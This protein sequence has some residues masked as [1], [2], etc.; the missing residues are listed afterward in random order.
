MAL[1]V[2]KE[3]ALYA[4]FMT[5]IKARSFVVEVTL[6]NLVENA[7]RNS[8][9]AHAEAEKAVLQVRFMCELVALASLAAHSTHGLS[10]DLLKSWHA[11][12]TF[13]L[14][15]TINPLC[16]PAP[17]QMTPEP[18][19]TTHL[20]VREAGALNAKG[21]ESIYNSCGQLLHRGVIKHVL[22]RT[23][24]V[25]DLDKIFGWTN[26][27]IGL[28]NNHIIMIQKHKGCF[29]ARLGTDPND[30][31]QVAWAE[32]DSEFVLGRR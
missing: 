25:Y 3:I 4:N 15:K 10:K 6:N 32:A 31:V 8:P 21:L 14:L 17:V 29:I 23:P 19:G 16:F 26:Q 28:L 7:D 5:E 22:Q 9:L 27:I 1:K 11:D 30:P 13:R 20:E 24:R 2:N 18:D 12:R